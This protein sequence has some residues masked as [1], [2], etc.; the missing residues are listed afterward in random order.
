[1]DRLQ[2]LAPYRQATYC[3]NPLETVLRQDLTAG[4]GYVVCPVLDAPPVGFVE[5]LTAFA[6]DPT[7]ENWALVAATLQ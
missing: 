6:Q 4:K 5:A 7:D 2:I 1:M 3:A